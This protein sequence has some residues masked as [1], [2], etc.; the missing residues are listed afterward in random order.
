[1]TNRAIEAEAEIVA[2]LGYLLNS[3]PA[4]GSI[5]PL[6]NILDELVAS[7]TDSRLALPGQRRSLLEDLNVSI[8]DVGPR[9]M[10][11]VNSSLR[12]VSRTSNTAL[13]PSKMTPSLLGE[14]LS[15]TRRLTKELREVGTIQAAWRDLV[16]AVAAAIPVEA[17]RT[18]LRLVLAILE[19]A[20]HDCDQLR[21]RLHSIVVD[22]ALGRMENGGDRDLPRSP[23]ERLA[24]CED[25]I[26]R[27]PLV[28]HCVA[29]VA[30]SGARM[31]TMVLEAGLVTFFD[32]E[33]AT[34]NARHE[35]GQ[36][37]P[38]REELRRLDESFSEMIPSEH[39]VVLVR[40]DLGFRAA[41]GALDEG[42]RRAALI[43]GQS[44]LSARA[45]FWST[46]GWN[47]LLVDDRQSMS[48][49]A[50]EDQI[51]DWP[52]SHELEAVAG[53]LD[54]VAPMI[55]GSLD[56]LPLQLVEA[57]DTALQARIAKLPSRIILRFRV[58]E[59]VASYL[60]L[61]QVDDLF[62][63][64]AGQWAYD[65]M[66]HFIDW[67]IYL[68]VAQ[69]RYDP[70]MHARGLALRTAI[71]TW[72][73]SGFFINYS[74]ALD[75]VDELLGM[76]DS[77]LERAGIQEALALLSDG[78]VLLARLHRAQELEVLLVSR[79]IRVRNAITHGNPFTAH[80]VGT[81]DNY[82]MYLTEFV[83]DESLNAAAKGSQ[84]DAVISERRQEVEAIEILATSGVRLADILDGNSSRME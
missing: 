48:Q 71:L 67:E 79:L 77:P 41:A 65:N 27:D 83:L 44:S 18:R 78:A 30:F 34:P 21:T 55:G 73:G 58:L 17:A 25:L 49:F 8:R 37:F 84:L 9:L 5:L 20:G 6:P 42:W 33:W 31:R 68:A 15:S 28:G 12:T 2:S 10:E 56:Q 50:T 4:A 72:R 64:A 81:V 57:V 70:E 40:I 14:A 13:S 11:A 75:H 19:A 82:L 46:W 35:S 22:D 54:E 59:L 32:S 39:G 53:K 45:R 51:D 24:L 7:I 23:T 16:A 1:V 38:H 61:R 66:R 3:K 43:A 60:A 52:N 76:S 63:I 26:A 80:G 62:D 36:K 47:A 69:H 29:W 74:V